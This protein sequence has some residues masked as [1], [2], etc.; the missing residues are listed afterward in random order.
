MGKCTETHGIEVNA[1]GVNRAQG[2]IHSGQDWLSQI[3]TSRA[4][5]PDRGHAR[6]HAHME[7][8][9]QP[10][11]AVQDPN[12][13][14]S[15]WGTPNSNDPMC[16]QFTSGTNQMLYR[17]GDLARYNEDGTFRIVDRRDTQVK[18]RGY[19]IELGEMKIRS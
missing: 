2:N 11:G 18:L 15:Y 3:L 16:I 19:R 17:S 5:R 12:L 6:G 14:A 4:A 8:F 7:E 10:G 1:H 13:V 9:L